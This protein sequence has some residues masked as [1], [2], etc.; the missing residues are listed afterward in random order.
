M[1][2]KPNYC[3]N[4]GERIERIEWKVFTSRRFC[5]LC[6]KEFSFADWLPRVSG[7]VVMILGVLGL[8]N[9][10]NNVE[11]PLEIDSDHV[12]NRQQMRLSSV[13]QKRTERNL[14]ES[15]SERV[16]N[17]TGTKAARGEFRL[18]QLKR[19]T[20]E[21]I[22]RRRESRVRKPQR[23]VSTPTYFCGAET[24]KGSPCSRRVKG[25]GRCWQHKGREAI[26]HK[27]D[28]LIEN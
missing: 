7:A 11:K 14:K 2:Y 24:K 26:V 19:E 28:L 17:Q 27:K 6:E 12:V 3:C 8:G 5:S 15:E 21:G 23:V 13:K 10:L 25:G 4:C 1:L 22:F 20:D 16:T 18:R 9:Y